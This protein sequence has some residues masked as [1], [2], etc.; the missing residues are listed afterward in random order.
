M[1]YAELKTQ[2]QSITE[3]TFDDVS[4]AMFTEQAEQKIY[5]AVQVANLSQASE[6]N[7]STTQYSALSLLTLMSCHLFLGLHQT[8]TTTPSCTITT[9]R[10]LLL[11]PGPH[12]LVITL[13]A[14]CLMARYLKRFAT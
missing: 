11:L 9:T 10:S 1:N 12:G 3:N 13:M 5:N 4:L 6:G 14:H 8:L 7:L 2:I